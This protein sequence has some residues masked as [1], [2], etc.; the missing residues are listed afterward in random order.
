MVGAKIADAVAARV[1]HDGHGGY[2]EVIGTIKATADKVASGFTGKEEYHFG[3]LS[4]AEAAQ[5]FPVLC[6]PRLTALPHDR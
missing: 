2:E 1:R 5:P 6:C 4:K 3:D